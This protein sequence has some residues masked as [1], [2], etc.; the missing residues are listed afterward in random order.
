MSLAKQFHDWNEMNASMR[1]EIIYKHYAEATPF[2]FSTR[3]RSITFWQMANVKQC[4]KREINTPRNGEIKH[5]AAAESGWNF[6]YAKHQRKRTGAVSYCWEAFV[7]RISYPGYA[8][9]KGKETNLQTNERRCR[10]GR[11]RM[12]CR[13]WRWCQGSEQW[14]T[15]LCTGNTSRK[16]KCAPTGI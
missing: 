12:I 11:A 6:E 14:R 8:K 2:G 15:T 7:R 3:N 4:R 9:T 10:R 13:L 16:W 1:M 5:V